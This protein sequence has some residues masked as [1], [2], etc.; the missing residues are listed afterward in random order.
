MFVGTLC[1]V[2]VELNDSGIR[3]VERISQ[4]STRNAFIPKSFSTGDAK[5]GFSILL[6]VLM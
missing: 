4:V 5:T 3:H 2:I 1:L 6:S